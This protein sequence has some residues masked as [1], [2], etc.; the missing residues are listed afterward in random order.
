MAMR[1]SAYSL[2]GRQQS[3]DSQ[4]AILDLKRDNSSGHP[5]IATQRT[6]T[7]VSLSNE[8]SEPSACFAIPVFSP[9]DDPIA[10]LNKAMAFLTA[11]AIVK[12]SLQPN[13]ATSSG[14]T[15]SKNILVILI[16]V[17][18]TSQGEILQVDNKSCKMLR[19][20]KVK[21]FMAIDLSKMAPSVLMANLSNYGSNVLSEVPHSETYQNDMDNQRLVPETRVV[22]KRHTKCSL[23]EVKLGV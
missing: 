19:T 14:K 16:R 23:N 5:S 3:K 1:Q 13:N 20:A 7:L 10:C 2:G 21:D 12:L 11:V 17:N 8:S 9:R 6:V 4:T 22:K 18:A 15:R